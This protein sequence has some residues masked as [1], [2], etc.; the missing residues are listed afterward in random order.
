MHRDEDP[1]R[2]T[3]CAGPPFDDAL[4]THV[5]NNNAFTPNTLR[6]PT[7]ALA[8]WVV[9]PFA[10]LLLPLWTFGTRACTRASA[11][12]QAAGPR[13]PASKPRSS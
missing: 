2:V 4:R 1:R 5:E 9:Y 11:C 3:C 10:V 6:T 12:E 8:R 7:D 13:N